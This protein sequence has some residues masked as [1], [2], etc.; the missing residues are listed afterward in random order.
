[1]RLQ[2]R[3]A[4]FLWFIRIY[5]TVQPVCGNYPRKLSIHFQFVVILL[6]PDFVVQFDGVVCL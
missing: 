2:K 5:A 4:L 3:V 1:M 6:T